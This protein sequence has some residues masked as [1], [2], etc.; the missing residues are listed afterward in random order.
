MTKS[1]D[2]PD[3][4]VSEP[5][6]D[7]RG[8]P[9]T[10]LVDTGASDCVLFSDVMAE[11]VSGL[12]AGP[13]LAELIEAVGDAEAEVGGVEH[14]VVGEHLVEA[15]PLALVDEMAVE[16]E[17]L[18]DGEGVGDVEHGALGLPAFEARL[19]LLEKRG[20]AFGAIG[21]VEKLDLGL[22]FEQQGRLEW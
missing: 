1:H 19:A 3:A 14:E 22:A 2:K 17:Q 6:H 11:R 8:L 16:R 12:R 20:G 15:G 5:D 4:R 21:G 9:L 7:W 18:M 10:L 13:R